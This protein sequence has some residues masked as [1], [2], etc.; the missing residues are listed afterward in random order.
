MKTGCV[1]F[2][3][4]GLLVDSE[5][6]WEEAGKEI[7][8]KHGVV[9]SENDYA[10]S[11]GLRTQEWIELWFENFKINASVE[12]GIK[13]VVEAATAMIIEKGKLMPGVIETLTAIQSAGHTIG[14]A[15]SSPMSL[16][17]AVTHEFGINEFF[18]NKSSAEFL[19]FGK[20]HPQVYI[21]CAQSLGYVPHHC[22]AFEDSF[23][24]MIAAK[25]AR[26]KCIV[27]PTK[28]QWQEKKWQ[29]ADYQLETLEHFRIEMLESLFQ[30]A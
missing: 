17:N 23:N 10:S 19:E 24:G 3:M 12:E 6:L 20:P 9:L 11:V 21:D 29:A 22:V 18:K 28:I 1:I 4:D 30:P 16:I 27:V 8:L 14:L 26:M 25:A 15:S 13:D 7:L 5:P 2:D